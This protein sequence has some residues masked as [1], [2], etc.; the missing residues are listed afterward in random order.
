[1][2]LVLATAVVGAGAP[3]VEEEAGLGQFESDGG[4]AA[5]DEFIDEHFVAEGAENQTTVQVIRH[6]DGADVLTREELL[7]ELEFQ[8]D[9]RAELGPALAADDPM[10]GVSNLLALYQFGELFDGVDATTLEELDDDEQFAL[11]G[12]LGFEGEDR[13]TVVDVFQVA[14]LV[15][16]DV[17]DVTGLNETERQQ[18]AAELAGSELFDEDDEAVILELLETLDGVPVQADAL[19]DPT[20][21]ER[22]A[23][24]TLLGVEELPPEVCLD[25]LERLADAGETAEQRQPPL[26]CQ[27]WAISEM[28]DE[29][30]TAAVE[31][32]LGPDG[33]GDALALMPQSYN[34]GSTTARARGLF[35]TQQTAGGDFGEGFDKAVTDT[36]LELRALA[37]D[38]DR[39]YLVF[40][41]ALLGDELD[42]SLTDSLVLVGPF[43]LLFVIAVL[44]V[45]Y[46]D[47]VDILLGVGGV[48]TTVLWTFGFMG[49]TGIAFNQLMIAVPV[50]LIGLSIDY[51]IHVFMRHRERRGPETGSGQAMRVALAGVGVALVWVT[52]TAAIGFLSNLVSPLGPLR[53]FG[54]TSALGIVAALL[55]FGG[56]VPATKLELDE[57]LERR[58]F[59]RRRRAFG[60][61]DSR[62]AGVLELG[63]TAARRAPV[64][65]LVLALAVSAVGVYGAMQVDTSFEQEEFI[66]ED[67]PDWSQQLPEPLAP[68]EYQVTEDLSFVQ[69]NFQQ[70][71][72]N[73]E[74]LIRPAETG[75]GTPLVDDEVLLWLESTAANASEQESTYI[76]PNGRPDVRSPLS[77]LRETARLA[78]ESA[79][80]DRVPTEGVPT[81]NVSLLYEEMTAVNPAAPEVVHVDDGPQAL[82]MRIGID[83]EA[84]QQ[85]ATDDLRAVAAHLEAESDGRLDVV[86][87]GDPVT[88]VE[89]ESAIL[90]TV[91]ESLVLTLLAVFAFLAVA[92]RLTGNAASLGIVTL[93]PVLF[94]VTWILGT[95]WLVGV[96]FNALTG[97]I[98][99]LTIGLGIAYSIHVSARYE[100]ERRRQ[101]EIWGALETTVTGTGGALL[102]SAATTV[103]GFG[104]LVVA[105]LP[106]LQQFGL[107]T[108]LTIVYAFLA[109][110]LVLPSLLVLWTRYLGPREPAPDTEP[111]DPGST[112]GERTGESN[113]GESTAGETTRDA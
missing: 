86:A 79:L 22:D 89:V 9:L 76:L 63:A 12:L 93:L 50:L 66:A 2:V 21:T 23:V 94:A 91:F 47:V 29:A 113:T 101:D 43:A 56:L 26:A 54:V 14:Q 10:T 103:G 80:A 42:Q 85:A 13:E 38:A 34:P 1:M 46:R 67:P 81:E 110:V 39:E 36:Q 7:A 11:A 51:A 27:T 87:T 107:V 64:V 71:G 6:G 108:A 59:D 19:V 78:P 20:A 4:A 92:Y 16:R 74:L 25:E 98:T 62:L 49:W 31:A 112:A 33:Q 97:T 95:M 106:A 15:D 5:A 30:F 18:R 65:V 40:G 73:G 82:R 53:E 35:V 70:V 102:G 24:T 77:E 72:N 60:T 52:A 104:T 109:S 84:T 99:A 32:V 111:D 8:A 3:L 88:A 55:V 45:A 68:A 100:L 41:L 57:Q 61:G 105:I 44:T 48:L 90:S 69:E 75:E 28:D 17:G 37:E 96:P 83:G 58:G